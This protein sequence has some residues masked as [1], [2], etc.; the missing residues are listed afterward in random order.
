MDEEQIANRLK[1]NIPTTD[2]LVEKQAPPKTQE[3]QET[4]FVNDLGDTIDMYK[5]YDYFRVQPQYRGGDAEQKIQTIYRWAA[6]IAQSTDYLAVANVISA[7][8]SGQGAGQIGMSDL[9]RTYQY[10]KLQ[11]QIDHLKQEQGLL[12]G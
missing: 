11:K 1:Q 9:D 10:V 6:G 8:M 4:G 7:Y 3:P 2:E 5:L 12:N